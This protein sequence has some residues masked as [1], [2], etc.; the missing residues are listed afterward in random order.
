MVAGDQGR[1]DR[2]EGDRREDRKSVVRQHHFEREENAG[3]RRVE[4]CGDR[5]RRRAAEHRP[6]VLRGDLEALGEM[7]RKRAAKGH[8][9]SL[10]PGART[11]A[12]GR[13]ADQRVQEARTEAQGP[14]RLGPGLD[15]LGHTLAADIGQDAARPPEKEK[16]ADKAPPRH[17]HQEGAPRV[18][19]PCARRQH[20]RGFPVGENGDRF[21][22]HGEGDH[23]VGGQD[24]GDR[25]EEPEPHVR[26]RGR[27]VIRRAQPGSE[28]GGSLG[29]TG[30]RA[31][32]Y[33]S[34]HFLSATSA[35]P[36]GPF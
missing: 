32:R 12:E 17:G 16:E 8:R 3:D 13:R 22:P 21:D 25:R 24:A 34:S 7:H 23:P 4:G 5:R 14:R 10:A 18:E 28:R 30:H 26:E 31:G 19:R 27:T 33:H 9:R 6:A 11:G 20:F 29:G 36:Q 2:G 15:H 35:A 1:D